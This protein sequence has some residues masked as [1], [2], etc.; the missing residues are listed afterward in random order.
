MGCFDDMSNCT[1]GCKTQDHASYSECLRTKAPVDK[2]S[3]RSADP[4]YARNA[5]NTMEISEYR[6]ARAQGIQPKTTS[7]PDIRYAVAASK[8]ADTALTIT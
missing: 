6:A 8:K 4:L 1:S 7:L 5:L 3:T 2:N